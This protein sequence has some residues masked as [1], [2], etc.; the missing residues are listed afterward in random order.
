[1]NY[2][3]ISLSTSFRIGED[4]KVKNKM[5][6]KIIIVF[7]VNQLYIKKLQFNETQKGSDLITEN[8]IDRYK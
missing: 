7:L 8:H 6:G 1:M 2:I 3:L 5:L 4:K